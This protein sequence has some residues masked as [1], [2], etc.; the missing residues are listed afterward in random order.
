MYRGLKGILIF[1]LGAAVGSVVTWR[2]LKNKYEQIVQEEIDSFKAKMSE[3]REAKLGE[4]TDEEPVSDPLREKYEALTSIYS[5]EKGGSVSVKN[6]SHITILH[7][8]EF[9]EDKNY[10]PES[11]IYWADGVLSDD[12]GNII[13]D[14]DDLVGADF[15]DHFGEYEEYSVYIRNDK[16]NCEYE[17]TQDLREYGDVFVTGGPDLTDEE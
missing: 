5:T 1:T 10:E 3:K 15:A 14:V 16:Y 12:Q 11:L 13:E 8:D 6:N 17:I 7:P 2:A 9:A 4:P